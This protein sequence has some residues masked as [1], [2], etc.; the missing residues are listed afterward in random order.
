[1]TVAKRTSFVVLVVSFMLFLIWPRPLMTPRT[2]MNQRRAVLNI[3]NVGNAERKYA[4]ERPS[5]GY[6]CNLSDLTTQDPEGDLVD[7]VLASGM[8]AGY[9]FKLQ[10]PQDNAPKVTRYTI[11]AVPTIPGTTGDYALC[12][13]QSGE[14]WYSEKGSSPSDCLAVR[15]PVERKY[16]VKH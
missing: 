16:R 7:S 3:T 13:D 14:V 8:K 12:A 1:M 10:C 5:I 2:F 15:K 9:Y 11:T 6:A 4:A